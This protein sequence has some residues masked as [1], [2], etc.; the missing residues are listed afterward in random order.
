M[1]SVDRARDVRTT[2]DTRG[3]DWPRFLGGTG[4]NKDTH[5]GD[6]KRR[7]PGRMVRV[8]SP[9]PNDFGHLTVQPQR[10]NLC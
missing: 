7:G 8:A 4:P 10:M 9:A 1:V 5:R 3:F 2:F 6:V